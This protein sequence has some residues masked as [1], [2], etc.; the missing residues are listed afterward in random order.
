MWTFLESIAREMVNDTTLFLLI[1]GAAYVAV[2]NDTGG[3]GAGTTGGTDYTPVRFSLAHTAD[4]F[5]ASGGVGSCACSSR[6]VR[7]RLELA[8]PGL[9]VAVLRGDH[10][11]HAPTEAHW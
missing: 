8:G 3:R 9:A 4:K 7:S 5:A 6:A 11:V 10:E 1:T 2:L